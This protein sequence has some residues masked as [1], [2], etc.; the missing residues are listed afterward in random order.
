VAL[1]S[2][3]EGRAKLE[4]TREVRVLHP[5]GALLVPRAALGLSLDTDQA[6]AQLERP[7]TP[8]S[9]FTR[10]RTAL[11]GAPAEPL[12]VEP[13]YRFDVV[14]A[15][16]WLSDLAPGLRRE[17][18]DARLDLT[19]HERVEARSGREL[20]LGASLTRLAGL[21]TADE[22]TLAFTELAPKIPTST[23]ANVDPSLVLSEY[24]TDFAKRGGPRVKNIAR[25]AGY[26]DGTLMAPGQVWSFNRTVGPRTLERGFIDA[27]VIVADEVEP[28]V[29]GGVCQVATTL[30]AA[31]VLGGLDVV[32][33]RS[34]SRPSGYAP[35][36]LD[37]TVIDGEVD[38]QLRNPYSVP[39]IE[40]AF[41]PVPTRIRVEML[42]AVPPGKVEHTYAVTESEDFF[43]RV[44]RH[45]DLRP[46]Q[47]KR[48]QKGIPGYKVVSTVR[49]R[50]VDGTERV[51]HY[52]STYYPVPEV[53]WVGRDVDTD[54]LPA[55]PERATHTEVEGSGSGEGQSVTPASFE[56]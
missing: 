9:L 7:R 1:S 43:R 12:D 24:E 38:L 16:A 22:L 21:G 56:R 35:L 55:L 6:R 34:H 13:S 51:R 53:Y 11:G 23:L 28:G 54:H 33:R 44:A 8:S 36:G 48:Q 42:G 27:P 30:F 5:D 20:D 40:H 29:G 52:S 10:V 32:K 26:L 31:G 3:L 14:R 4:A 39:I 15:A 50:Y 37:A 41:L 2:W 19:G 49:T 46:D 17:P 47:V 45:D 18:V 25:A